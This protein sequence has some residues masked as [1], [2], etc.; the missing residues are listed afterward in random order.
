MPTYGYIA[1]IIDMGRATFRFRNQLFM[2]DV[3]KHHGEAGEQYSYPHSH[4][5]PRRK[6]APNPAFD[7]ARF[8]CSMLDEVYA[9]RAPPELEDGRRIH[10]EQ[11]ETTSPLYNLLCE[12]TRDIHGKP[13][14]RFQGFDLYKMIAR[15]MRG[16]VP[17]D[18]LRKTCFRQF[19]VRWAPYRRRKT[20]P[21]VYHIN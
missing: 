18:Q 6:V 4:W 21:T 8:A 9:G 7:L 17:L 10:T 11:R 16:T 13:I 5:Q 1:K 3:F 15:R 20:Q 2:G 12:W 19:R 14:Y